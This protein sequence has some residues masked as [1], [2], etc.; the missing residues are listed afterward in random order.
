MQA[1]FT[2]SYL[3]SAIIYVAVILFSI[4]VYSGSNGYP[5][6]SIG[7]VYNNLKVRSAVNSLPYSAAAEHRV[8]ACVTGRAHLSSIK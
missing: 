3:H 6:S 4:Y 7:E 5:I 1:V 8:P 2:S